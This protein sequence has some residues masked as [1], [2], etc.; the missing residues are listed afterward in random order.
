[1]DTAELRLDGNG[2]AG[3][4]AEAFGGDV[5][6]AVRA[7]AHCPTIGPVAE[8]DAYVHA[9]GLVLRCRACGNV[10]LRVVRLRDRLLV[11]VSGIVRLELIPAAAATASAPRARRPA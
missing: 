8:L 7:C 5:T 3:L 2:A 6:A 11:D 9:P 4:L 1:M 10:A